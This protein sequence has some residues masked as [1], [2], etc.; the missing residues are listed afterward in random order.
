M[1]FEFILYDRSTGEKRVIL[2]P[3]RA[4]TPRKSRRG[5]VSLSSYIKRKYLSPRCLE[6]RIATLR[7][8]RDYSFLFQEDGD[9]QPSSSRPVSPLKKVAMDAEER[10][11]SVAKVFKAGAQKR[12]KISSSWRGKRK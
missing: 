2:V 4:R 9:R 3:R 12:R 1:E 6:D 7:Y 8:S 11:A 5:I 10:K